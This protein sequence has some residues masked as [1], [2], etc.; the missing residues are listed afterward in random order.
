M[1]ETIFFCIL[2]SDFINI[3]VLSYLKQC[4]VSC[5]GTMQDN[6]FL[7]GVPSNP[8]INPM[9]QYMTNRDQKFKEK[10]DSYTVLCF[11]TPPMRR[12]SLFCP[13]N[14]QLIMILFA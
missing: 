11:D 4:M 7:K 13:V 2:L 8:Y 12:R 1:G 9:L 10:G 5:S 14:R 3:S 6:N